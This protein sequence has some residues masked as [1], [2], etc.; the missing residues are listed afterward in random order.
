MTMLDLSTIGLQI[1]LPLSLIAWLAFHP[2]RGRLGFVVQVA[3]TAAAL[4]AL[5]LG[6]VWMNPPWWTPYV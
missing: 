5:L 3:A 4:A 6:T 2:I 1:L